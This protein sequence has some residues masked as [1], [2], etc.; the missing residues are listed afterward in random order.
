MEGDKSIT[1]LLNFSQAEKKRKKKSKV[2][3]MKLSDQESAV[4]KRM[5]KGKAVL[6]KDCM[7]ISSP[8]DC[9]NTI[10]KKK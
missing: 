8:L 10:L 3:L 1:D 5:L 9:L 6:P 2:D 7:F 4:K